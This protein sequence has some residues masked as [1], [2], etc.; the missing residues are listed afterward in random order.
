MG[1]PPASLLRVRAARL[2]AANRACALLSLT[3]KHANRRKNKTLGGIFRQKSTLQ[4]LESNY[5]TWKALQLGTEHAPVQQPA[6]HVLAA[7]HID[8]AVDDGDDEAMEDAAAATGPEPSEEFKQRV[9]AVLE[10]NELDG[11]RSSKMGQD[12]FLKLLALFNAAGVHF[13]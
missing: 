10:S 12:D 6:G 7:M 13:A 3:H 5:R 1:R 8:T 4:L 11:Q 9:L 2:R